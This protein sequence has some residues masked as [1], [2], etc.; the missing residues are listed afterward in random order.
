MDNL[1]INQDLEI[2][3]LEAFTPAI[4]FE[5]ENAEK[6]IAG[7]KNK[8][9]Q[10][11][12]DTTTAKGRKEIASIA[13]KVSK[14]KTFLDNIG[15]SLVSEWKEKSKLVDA[16]RKLIRD[17]LDILKTQVREPLTVWEGEE[18]SRIQNI[19]NRIMQIKALS[20]FADEST[21]AEIISKQLS[22]AGKIVIGEEFGEFAEEA[23]LEKK[24]TISTLFSKMV[25][26][27]QFEADQAELEKLRS[28]A[29]YREE[30][31]A[32]VKRRFEQLE[33]EKAEAIVKQHE[34]EFKAKKAELDRLTELALA[35]K[36]KQEAEA[37]SFKDAAILEKRKQ[38]AEEAERI[39][40]A[41]E[42]KR[43]SEDQQHREMI[44]SEALQAL[45][46]DLGIRK[47]IAE[48]IIHSIKLGAIPHVL[49]NY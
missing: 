33:R 37:K 5:H 44:E 16:E 22:E 49:I 47:D 9:L 19:E 35:E 1:I 20:T 4:L 21:T 38:D 36:A 23:E 3:N 40:K 32:E 39:A 26:R 28:E 12:P 18:Q 7:I 15:K 46:H 27:K 13:A 31:E 2:M 14:S 30:Q 11:E 24:H 29:R 17:Q 45:E 34:A 25:T 41:Q 8:A 43:R 10:H 42:E 6:I 48:L